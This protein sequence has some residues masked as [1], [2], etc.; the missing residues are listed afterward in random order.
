[1]NGHSFSSHV[2][3]SYYVPLGNLSRKRFPSD[4]QRK[5]QFNM[6]LV[7]ERSSRSCQ[8]NT[9][10]SKQSLCFMVSIK[11]KVA[12]W[13]FGIVLWFSSSQPLEI[14]AWANCLLDV[15]SDAGG[16]CLVIWAGLLWCSKYA[17]PRDC[18]AFHQASLNFP[19]YRKRERGQRI[20]YI[21]VIDLKASCSRC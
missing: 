9:H 15:C 21:M 5:M 8:F 16:P 1:M 7:H 13:L 2:R 17:V 18:G 4:W 12:W 11:E 14:Q 10:M 20:I 19:H 6:H 3:R